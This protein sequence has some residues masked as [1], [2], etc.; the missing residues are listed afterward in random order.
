M[1]QL[2]A[3]TAA[4]P[5][6][7][8]D[9]L[10]VQVEQDRCLRVKI[11]DACGLTC[12]FCHNEGTPVAVDNLHSA[13]ASMT[14]RGRSGRVSIY[15]AHNGARF[16]PATVVPDQEFAEVLE[17]L[18]DAL[19][20][21]EL[22][23]TGGEPSLHP[24]LAEIVA[25]GSAAGLRVCV[26]SNGENLA[27]LMPEC[28]RAGLDHVNFSI[29]GTTPA[30]LAQVQHPKFGDLDRA[31]KKIRALRDSVQAALDHGVRA[32]ANIVV[33]HHGHAPRVRRLIE[34][35]APELSVRLLNSLDEGIA[36]IDAIES[37]MN[38][39]SAVPTG[40][41]VT[42]GASGWRSSYRLPSGRIVWSKRIRPVRL[43]RTCA[44]CR[45]NNGTDCH[46]G[47]Y[48][49]RLYRD[50]AGGFQV[51]VCIQRMDLCL[52]VTEFLDSTVLKEILDLRA[53]EYRRLSL[54]SR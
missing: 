11:I 10:P 26:T 7:F 35:Y 49:V 46:E 22:H 51:G 38:D 34:E 30:E 21:D 12:T 32:S 45:F 54:T 14:G 19:D 39:L 42:A 48:G 25:A 16:L 27:R 53:A 24:R 33:P 52:P 13:P 44:G 18:R 20:L 36:S 1:G 29:F 5:T 9:S 47:F 2:S 28:A 4:D 23:L 37:I 15:L 43:P 8:T 6:M 50:R 17:L 3:A 41:R 31:A 40:H